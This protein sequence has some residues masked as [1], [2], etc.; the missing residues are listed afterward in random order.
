MR[1]I[2]LFTN[3]YQCGD[4]E[5]QKE[6]DYCFN[7]NRSGLFDKVIYFENRPTYKDFFKATEEYPNDINI[8]AN[9]DVYFNETIKHFQDLRPNEAYA[10]TRWEL[11][12]SK[13]VRFEQKHQYN[14]EAKSKHSQDVWA[15]VG[16][17]KGVFGDFFIGVPG[18]DNRIAY[19]INKRY[20]LTNPS[21]RIQCIH[22]HKEQARSY[23][24]S[25]PVPPPYMWVDVDGVEVPGSG[26]RAVKPRAR[27]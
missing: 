12:G 21:D 17:V 8:L 2:N 4:P 6:L 24:I 5:R 13:P 3:H 18:C 25:T 19:E 9:S 22:K 7:K 27:I 14:K 15:F 23:T 20:T 16:T 1:K 11:E 10:I 26:R